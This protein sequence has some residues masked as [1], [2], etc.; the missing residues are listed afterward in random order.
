M[1]RNYR[2]G[3]QVNGEFGASIPHTEEAIKTMLEYRAPARKPDEVIWELVDVDAVA[4]DMAERRNQ[5]LEEPPEGWL[6][7]YA[8]FLRDKEGIHYE[9]RCIRGHL[10][11]AAFSI[12]EMDGINLKNFRAKFVQHIYI[13]RNPNDAIFMYRDGDRILE[14]DGVQQRFIQVMTR[15]GPRSSIKYVD[16]V[17]NPTMY[18]TVK[19]LDDGVIKPEH[20]TMALEF[21]SVHG[22]GAERS[23]GWGTYDILSIEEVTNE[24]ASR[25]LVTAD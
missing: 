9:G 8:G 6:P 25:E 16:Y 7:G 23:Q 18:F 1:F 4:T 19:L 11:D 14:P 22:M 15:Q 20:L 2:I 10:K 12:R 21:G 24:P 17:I 5:G 13:Q 3:I